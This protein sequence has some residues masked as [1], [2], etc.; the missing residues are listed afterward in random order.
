M[1]CELVFSLYSASLNAGEV[2]ELAFLE[3]EV[4]RPAG[5]VQRREQ[6]LMIAES[7]LAAVVS[8]RQAA[9]AAIDEL[10]LHVEE[11][12]LPDLYDGQQ[13]R[14]EAVVD[15]VGIAHVD[16]AAGGAHQRATLQTHSSPTSH[17]RLS[18]MG[19]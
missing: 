7:D 6:V 8:Q 10:A 5:G 1:L 18:V 11:A 15:A 14:V 19:S 12:A 16:A 3:R 2:A 9:V 17:C 4:D 13:A